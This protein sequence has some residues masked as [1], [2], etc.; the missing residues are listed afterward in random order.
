MAQKLLN[1]IR[2]FITVER[3]KQTTQDCVHMFSNEQSIFPQILIKFHHALQKIRQVKVQLQKYNQSKLAKPLQDL[4]SHNV[5][6]TVI[7]YKIWH[8]LQPK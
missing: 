4:F 7:L 8:F 1:Q 6:K 2:L 5:A 3:G